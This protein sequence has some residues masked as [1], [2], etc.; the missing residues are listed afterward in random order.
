MHE[1]LLKFF[2]NIS[3]TV[4]EYF[5]IRRQKYG[6]FSGEESIIEEGFVSP[7]NVSRWIRKTVFLQRLEMEK[8][9]AHEKH[10]S[11]EASCQLA[12]KSPISW[13]FVI[14]GAGMELS[15]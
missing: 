11:S 9:N 2:L 7:N 8:G 10:Q 3:C 15:I 4:L 12:F 14:L 5:I 6:Y 1:L 13:L